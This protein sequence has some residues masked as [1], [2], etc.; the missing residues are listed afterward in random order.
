MDQGKHEPF[1]PEELTRKLNEYL[2]KQI[3]LRTRAKIALDSMSVHRYSR[4]RAVAIRQM[5]SSNGYNT[6][7]TFFTCANAT[8]QANLELRDAI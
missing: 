2:A 5:K 7:L 3:R 1:D 4:L 8:E 6:P